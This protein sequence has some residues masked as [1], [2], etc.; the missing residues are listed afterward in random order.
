MVQIAVEESGFLTGF[1]S[2]RFFA[3]VARIS[4]RAVCEIAAMDIFCLQVAPKKGRE[5]GE[6]DCFYT[7]I[8]CPQHYN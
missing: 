8:I 4:S 5:Q 1:S 3:S 7:Q 6:P 2:S